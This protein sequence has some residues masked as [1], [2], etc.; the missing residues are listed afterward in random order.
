MQ[1]NKAFER[2]GRRPANHDRAP[3]AAGRSLSDN[4]DATTA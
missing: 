2:T 3:R 4:N 1:P